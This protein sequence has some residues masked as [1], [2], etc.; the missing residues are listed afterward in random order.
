MGLVILLLSKQQPDTASTVFDPV[1]Q[2]LSFLKVHAVAT[3]LGKFDDF[4]RMFERQLL[5]ERG[6]EVGL[7]ELAIPAVSVHEIHIDAMHAAI[8][9]LTSGAV[10]LART[11]RRG[12]GRFAAAADLAGQAHAGC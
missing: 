6:F 11:V 3:A 1:I 8:P 9:R 5:R 4:L 10:Y 7:Q 12:E 2:R